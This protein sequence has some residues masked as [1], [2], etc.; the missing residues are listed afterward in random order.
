M[1]LPW[2]ILHI[3]TTWEAL[4]VFFLLFSRLKP[5][6][7]R[8]PFNDAEDVIINVK[9][10]L[11]VVLNN[12]FNYCPQQMYAHWQTFVA[13]EENYFEGNLVYIII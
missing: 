11:G 8:Q 9:I 1:S 13:A 12:G 4:A 10:H 3:R 6:L 5:A 2:S 7:I